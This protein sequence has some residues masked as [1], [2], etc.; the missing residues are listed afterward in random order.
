MSEV[1]AQQPLA[2][3]EVLELSTMVTC[4]LS[5]M[6]LRSQG[7]SVIKID[8]GQGPIIIHNVAQ[9]QI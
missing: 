7:A 8:N 5:A 2:G 4:S 6:M 1:T 3:L 9:M